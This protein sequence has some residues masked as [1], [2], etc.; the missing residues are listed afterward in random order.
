MKDQSPMYEQLTLWD[1]PNATSSPG[2][3]DG[4]LPCNLP[5]GRKAS[6]SGLEVAPANH[7]VPPESAKG[8]ATSATSGRSSLASSK[9]GSR[10]S[11]S[12][13]KSHP[14]KLSA[15]SLRLISLTRFG[16]G[17]LLE[18]IGLPTNSAEAPLCTTITGGS[19]EYGQTWTPRVTPC[20]ER[21]WEHTASERR[22]GDIDCI[23]EVFAWPTAT[24]ND[25]SGS[26][27][28]RCPGGTIALKL[29]G[30]AVI[31]AWPTCQCMDTMEVC[32]ELENRSDKANAGGCANLREKVMIAA[33]PTT[34]GNNATGAGA[35][36]RTGGEN[37]QTAV[38]VASWNT[39]RATDGTHG[40][41]NQTGG[42][43]P[44][45]VQ[46]AAWLTPSVNDSKNDATPS[47]WRRKSSMSCEVFKVFLP[48]N[49]PH[50]ST[51]ATIK[52]GVYRLNP[53]F[54]AWL[55]GFPREWTESGL[56]AFAKLEASRSPRK[57]RGGR[58]S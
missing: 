58:C 1:T 11:F 28:Q 16:K 51:A 23:G 21:Y 44:P 5:D 17:I 25:S 49:D 35:Q 37:L 10:K 8:S 43:L 31:A 12:A 14:Q 7:S 45:D 15:L 22:T 13:S 34:T 3:L 20:G 36:G 46:L 32:R 50:S 57:K 42:A 29:P 19:I 56:M 27:Y 40:G 47:Q 33:W 38:N 9:R 26:Q 55:M 52:S 18:Q 53:Y 4:R 2:S 39:P 24:V 48:G 30:A 54:S 6:R 41:P